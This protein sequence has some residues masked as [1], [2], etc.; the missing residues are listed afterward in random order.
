MAKF[1]RRRFY[2]SGARDKYS[3][4]HTA[5][6]AQTGAVLTNSLYQHAVN[7]VPASPT[8]GMRKVKHTTINLCVPDDETNLW[9]CL[10][11]V[12]EGYSV[13]SMNNNPGASF[14]EPNNFVMACGVS[15]PN[16]GPIRIRSHV[17]RNLNSGDSI[18]LVFGT[19][20]A[21]KYIAGVVEYAI[22]LQ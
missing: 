14:Y 3:V 7:V 1:Y 2:K 20:Q 4:E 11:Y 8:Q 6:N 5:I 16:A 15:D 13:N 19:A 21:N 10:V 17:S 22:T 9:W 12:P 18:W